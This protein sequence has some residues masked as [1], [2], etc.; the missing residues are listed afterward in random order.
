[1]RRNF[2]ARLRNDPSSADEEVAKLRLQLSHFSLSELEQRGL[3]N[4]DRDQHIVMI[5][6]D[7]DEKRPEKEID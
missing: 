7:F 4:W 3:V 1:M 2:K 5:D 6:P